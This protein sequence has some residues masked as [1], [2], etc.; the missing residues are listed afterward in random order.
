MNAVQVHWSWGSPQCSCGKKCGTNF[1]S[2]SPGVEVDNWLQNNSELEWFMKWNLK[3]NYFSIRILK[4]IK[5][6]K[7]KNIKNKSK[8]VGPN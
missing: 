5:I 3:K 8:Q 4:I 2:L 7:N 6:S 1:F